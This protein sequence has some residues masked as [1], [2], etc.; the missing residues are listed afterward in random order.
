[1]VL[2]VQE[3]GAMV[4]LRGEN[5]QVRK[6]GALC[7]QVPLLSV[8]RLVIIGWVQV[9][10]Q[11]L[12]AL[13]ARGVDV[14]FMRRNGCL[15][16]TLH[17]SAGGSV[18]LRLAQYQRYLDEAYRLEFAKALIQAKI[19]SQIQWAMAQ[20]GESDN[21]AWGDS[22]ARLKQLRESVPARDT[23]EELRGAEGIASRIYFHLFGMHMKHLSFSGRTRRPAQDPAN[24]LLNLGY[25]FLRNECVALLDAHGLD[26]G[27]G[28]LHGV[29]YGRESLALDVMEPFRST[30]VDHLVARLANL[31]IIKEEH[32]LPD[33]Q[34]GF[35]LSPD[36]FRIFLDQ[37][38]KQMT[39]G[40]PTLRARIRGEI[41]RMRRA[42]L[43]G[44]P[45][46]AAGG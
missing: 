20:R 16:F 4:G 10:T 12:H 40:E 37:Y 25:A 45:Y 22:V 34:A 6:Q 7:Y 38:E 32:F 1:M 29:R 11:A 27:L 19:A 5:V 44:T 36:G 17:A 33:K 43:E 3:S 15:S 26:C 31:R 13:A 30:V 8:E 42:L 18:F 35:R 21:E 23:L 46:H 41:E 39:E 14:A 9:T 2:Y 28:F 24:A